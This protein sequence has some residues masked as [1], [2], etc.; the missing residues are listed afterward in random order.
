MTDIQDNLPLIIRGRKPGTAVT[1]KKPPGPFFIRNNFVALFT[2]FRG[3]LFL[4]GVNLTIFSVYPA[5]T[6]FTFGKIHI[7]GLIILNFGCRMWRSSPSS[8]HILD[9]LG[10]HSPI[11]ILEI[12]C[13]FLTISC[14][15]SILSIISW[16]CR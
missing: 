14:L 8:I 5:N 13:I 15:W 4:F 10:K 3:T 12:F 1:L 7:R 9:H 11:P 16:S 2:Q 6:Q